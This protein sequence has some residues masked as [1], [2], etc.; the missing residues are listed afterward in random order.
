MLIDEEIKRRERRFFV[1]R[2]RELARF[3]ES[4]APPSP[5]RIFNVFGPGGIGKSYLLREMHRT[6]R[7]HGA[8]SVFV[9]GDDMEPT[10]RSFLA[11]VTFAMEE[12]GLPAGQGGGG[13]AGKVYRCLHRAAE[14]SRLV[15]FIDTYEKLSNL[16]HWIRER[17]VRNL[18]GTTVLVIA[19]QTPL[20]GEWAESPAWRS[21]VTPLELGTF[22]YDETAICLSNY[23][24][25]DET[26]VANIHS[27]STGHP[28]V[29][30]LAAQLTDTRLARLPASSRTDI[31][32][33]LARR[34]LEHIEDPSLREL[35]EA[36]AALQTFNREKLSFVVGRTVSDGAMK[37]LES[38][39]FMKPTRYGWNMHRLVSS[40]I[41]SL[42]QRERPN[43]LER[44][45]SGA[46]IY[47]FERIKGGS[48]AERDISRF[49]YY[50][51]D[52]MVRSAFFPGSP[53]GVAGLYLEQAT[54]STFADVEEYFRRRQLDLQES[55]RDQTVIDF[56]HPDSHRR[57]THT[58]S[59]SHDMRETELIAATGLRELGPESFYILQDQKGRKLGIAVII[60]VH[61]ETLPQLA[62]IPVSRAYFR[63]LTSGLEK[64]YSTPPAEPAAVFIRMLD[65]LDPDEPGHR[66]STL[67]NLF[68]L[69]LSQGHIIASTPLDFF[70]ELLDRFGFQK[71][72]G[73]THYD[74]GSHQPADTYMLDLTGAR[75]TNYLR[76]FILRDLA[77]HYSEILNKKYDFTAREQ[78]VLNLVLQDLSNADI[79][80]SLHITE[81][82]VKKHVGGILRKTGVA[83]RTDLMNLL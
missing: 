60:P 38:F 35:V 1:G 24:L 82:T 6:A 32:G 58:V 10:V 55:P 22:T 64:F 77:N 51:G 61:R 11:N 81:V 9:D 29:V 53:D 70:V 20:R 72:E 39:W 76:T 19:G 52:E 44:L 67:Y 50:A 48:R 27:F 79:A 2:R 54:A 62:K 16:D 74:F 21:L 83:S 8:V 4:L 59:G 46:A 56:Q 49:F 57:F 14:S 45:R 71:V 78:E 63:N 40:A 68:P 26:L 66:S 37:R 5:G 7:D 31:L 73:A 12:A 69:L 41:L 80:D 25:L 13:A 42:I 28:L 34:W 18:P 3:A 75:L 65:W 30:S 33:I 15:F 36:A 47:F 23:G 43:I 17:F